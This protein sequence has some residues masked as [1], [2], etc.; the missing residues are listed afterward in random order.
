MSYAIKDGQPSFKIRESPQTTPYFEKANFFIETP[1]T[2]K[3]PKTLFTPSSKTD[4][5]DDLL[6]S[7]P[8][9]SR[10][11]ALPSP[12]RPKRTSKDDNDNE[13]EA[14]NSIE[15]AEVETEE[16]DECLEEIEKFIEMHKK[17]DDDSIDHDADE[18]DLQLELEDNPEVMD[19]VQEESGDASPITLE[20]NQSLVEEFSDGYIA[21]IAENDSTKIDHLEEVLKMAVMAPSLECSKYVFKAKSQIVGILLAEPLMENCK[22]YRAE[23]KKNQNEWSMDE[24]LS[25]VSVGISGIWVHEDFRRNKVAS[26][27]VKAMEDTFFGHKKLV[28]GQGY[29]FAHKSTE[30]A[31]FASKYVGHPQGYF[32]TY[33]PGK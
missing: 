1:N 2:P 16:P 32:L 13:K 33:S 20:A 26:R 5:M 15:E 10:R 22:V 19:D 7:P 27:L 17:K 30:G 28:K 9:S 21:K 24:V 6:I 4:F 12:V 25:R 14:D 31:I 29:A 3:T 23:K 11:H 18:I 8:K